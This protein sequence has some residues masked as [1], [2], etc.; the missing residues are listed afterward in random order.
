MDG[1]VLYFW[2]N[3]GNY[4][5]YCQARITMSSG[6]FQLREMKNKYSTADSLTNIIPATQCGMY[7]TSAHLLV[8]RW[9]VCIA[10]YS[11]PLS[12]ATHLSNRYLRNGLIFSYFLLLPV[13]LRTYGNTI[14]L[15]YC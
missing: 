10:Y 5:P 7:C 2:N 9:S 15:V 6:I 8:K 11:C 14:N 1:Q 12:M 4:F 3:F 13:N